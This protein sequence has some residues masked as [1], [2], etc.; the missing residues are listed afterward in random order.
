[1]TK[2]ELLDQIYDQLSEQYRNMDH[3]SIVEHLMEYEMWKI[4]KQKKSELED[5]LNQLKSIS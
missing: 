2:E 3:E 5:F 4:S 1:M